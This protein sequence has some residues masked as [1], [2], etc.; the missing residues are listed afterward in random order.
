MNMTMDFALLDGE[1]RAEVDMTQMKSKD[2]HPQAVAMMKQMGMDRIVSITRPGKKNQ[3]QIYPNLKSSVTTPLSQTQLDMFEKEPRIEKT[4][5]GKETIDGHPC[6][7]NKVVVTDS[8]G[9]THEST[10]WN[11][12][13]LKSFPVKIQTAEDDTTVVML[14]KQ[15]RLAKPDA[16]KF[17]VPSDYKHYDDAQ[18]FQQALISKMMSGA[19][20]HPQMPAGE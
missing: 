5:L 11:A 3:T 9:K 12:T 16:A 15:I 2:M 17:E 6:V 20:G 19:G 14:F 13:D 1:M 18:A 7:K 10:V 4:E 8:K